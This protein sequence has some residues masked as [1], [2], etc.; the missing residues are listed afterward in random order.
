MTRKLE[1]HKTTF[2]CDHKGCKR[3]LECWSEPDG[4]IGRIHQIGAAIN[5][6]WVVSIGAIEYCSCPKH[7]TKSQTTVTP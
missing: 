5:A 1:S 2:T 4:S 7:K 6:G 3:S